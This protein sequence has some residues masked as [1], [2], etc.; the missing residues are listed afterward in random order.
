MLAY[1]AQLPLV[2][3]DKGKYERRKVPYSVS[4]QLLGV[5][6]F[7]VWRCSLYIDS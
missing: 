5:P 4:T 7:F 3:R 1:Y 2:T 6:V